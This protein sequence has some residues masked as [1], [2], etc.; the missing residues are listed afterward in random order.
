MTSLL[1]ALEPSSPTTNNVATS[2]INAGKPQSVG[3]VPINYDRRV[4]RGSD[5]RSTCNVTTPSAIYGGL[6]NSSTGTVPIVYQ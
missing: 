5:T 4:L 6:T 1:C 3:T 2:A